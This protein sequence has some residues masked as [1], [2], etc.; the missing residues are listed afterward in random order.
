MTSSS[1]PGSV[2]L[3]VAGFLAL[4]MG[5]R[6]SRLGHRVRESRRSVLLARGTARRREMAVRAALGAG[7]AD[8]CVS[9]SRRLLCCSSSA[10]HLAFWSRVL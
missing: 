9:C 3:P 4:L 1:I 7:R 5:I 2:G 6:G 8:W 10:A